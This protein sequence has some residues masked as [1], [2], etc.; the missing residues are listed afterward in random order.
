MVFVDVF[1]PKL[2]TDIIS[3]EQRSRNMSRIRGRDTGP[4]LVV[5]R[6]A[7]KMGFRFRLYR[8]DL[9]GTPDLV[10]PKHRLAVF[11]HGCYWH[12]H[13][14]CRFAYSPKSRVEFW[15]KKFKQNVARDSRNQTALQDLGWRVL[16][17]WECETRNIEIVEDR[18]REWLCIDDVSTGSVQEVP[19]FQRVAETVAEYRTDDK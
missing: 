1:N 19:K 9:P 18:L 6:T 13:S 2:M 7:H 14:G 17:I 12:R 3:K 4:E 5:R 16:V 11:V 10:F 15:T 8:K